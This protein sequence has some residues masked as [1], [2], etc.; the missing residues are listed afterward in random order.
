[1]V[2]NHEIIITDGDVSEKF[3]YFLVNAVKSLNVVENTDLLTSTDGITD[4]IVIALKKYEFHP[5]ILQIKKSIN[6]LHISNFS[7][8]P[9]NL[10]EIETELNSLNAKKS[11]SYKNIPTKILKGNTGI[12]S[13]TLLRIINNEIQESHF[14]DELKFADVTPV[15][16]NG[17]ST[18]VKIFRP[19]SVLPFISKVFEGIMQKQ[20]STYFEK[21]L[22][23]YVRGHRKGYNTQNAITAMIEK[24]KASLDKQGY[25]GAT[26]LDI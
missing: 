22:S 12:C 18:N 21:L 26:I 7:F 5:N 13:S 16:K 4:E 23:P 14:P 20:I 25:S 2:D 24:W 15:F 11:S 6:R 1:M 8:K 17:D 19:V 10:S 9:P 3:N